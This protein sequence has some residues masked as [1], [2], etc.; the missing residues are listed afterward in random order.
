M[1]A[2]VQARAA[3]RAGATSA[4]APEDW[5]AARKVR[6]PLRQGTGLPSPQSTRQSALQSHFGSAAPPLGEHFAVTA[7]SRAQ[8]QRLGSVRPLRSES[9]CDGSPPWA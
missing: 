7:P 3:P 6:A 1:L 5:A 4:E 2:E 8:A 9:R